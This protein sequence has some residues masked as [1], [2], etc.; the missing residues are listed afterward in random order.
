MKRRDYGKPLP[1]LFDS[2]DAVTKI[3]RIDDKHYKYTEFW[4]GPLTMILNRNDNQGTLACRI[5]NSQVS[6]DVIR[7]FGP[8]YTTSVNYS[9]EK[10]LNDVD[11]IISLFGEFVDYIITDKNVLTK[12]P[13]TIIDCTDT[14][15]DNVKVLRQ[16]NNINNQIKN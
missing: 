5:P 1:V 15:S 14:N 4:P 12:T 8:L 7:Y 3:A 13:S 16:V 2:V 9:G 6:L 10:E 11:E